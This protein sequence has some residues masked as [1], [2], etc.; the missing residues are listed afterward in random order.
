[1]IKDVKR[2][3]DINQYVKDDMNSKLKGFNDSDYIN[4][5]PFYQKGVVTDSVDAA[6]AT[7]KGLGYTFHGGEQWKAPPEKKPEYTRIMHVNREKP[8]VGSVILIK[9]KESLSEFDE[10]VVKAVTNEYIIVSC[11]ANKHAITE[12]H[13]Y[14]SSMEIKP[15]PTERELVTNDMQDII[16]SQGHLHVGNITQQMADLLY[17]AGYRKSDK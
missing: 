1:M 15:T 8:P 4:G 2:E 6:V 14:I 13:F 10:V 9:H 16:S 11:A 12:Q 17:D 5:V 7:L 3:S